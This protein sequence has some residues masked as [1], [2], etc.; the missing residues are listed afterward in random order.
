MKKLSVIVPVYQVEQ[1]IRPCIES[2]FKQGIDDVDF[3]LII[4][5]DGTRDK[6]MEVIAD[7]IAQHDNVIVINQENLSLSVARNNGIAIAQGEYILMPDPDDLLFEN[8][9]SPLLAKA[10]ETKVDLVMAESVEIYAD[11]A[12][13]DCN[14]QKDVLSV[15]QKTGPQLFLEDLDPYYCQVWRILYRREFLIGNQLKFVPG[16]LYQDIPFTQECFLKANQCLKTSWILYV[17]RRGRQGSHT[18]SFGERNALDLCVAISKTWELTN[19]PRLSP[20][21]REKLESNVY[22]SFVFLVFAVL[23]GV[24]DHSRRVQIM[25]FL[26]GQAPRMKFTFALQPKLES[27]LFHWSPWLYMSFRCVV[28]KW[29]RLCS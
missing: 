26:H 12:P 17:Y 8:S 18:A 9:L 3:E 28:W 11:A 20:A 2:I 16:I 7:I 15:Q 14:I 10:L 27:V 4:V 19:I 13:P 21:L 22:A 29:R 1:Y 24:K 25:D 6:S 23:H 5:N